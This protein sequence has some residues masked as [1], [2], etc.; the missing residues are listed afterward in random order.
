MTALDALHRA[1]LAWERTQ[2]QLTLFE[3]SAALT[4]SPC[5][6]AADKRGGE[7][8]GLLTAEGL[9]AKQSTQPSTVD[10]GT[11]TATTHR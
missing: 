2:Q 4:A 8:P 1:R 7:R 10:G 6:R 3:G 5:S 11:F 9:T